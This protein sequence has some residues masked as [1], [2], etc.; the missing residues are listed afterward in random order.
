ME[1]K[2][3]EKAV[4]IWRIYATVLLLV[5]GFLCGAVA[6]F[7]TVIS[8][9]LLA[10]GSAAY[11]GAVFLYLPALYNSYLFRI[12][13]DKIIITKGVIEKKQHHLFIQRVQYVEVN[14]T[15]I[16]KKYKTCTLVFHTAGANLTLHQIDYTVAKQ[17]KTKNKNG[18]TRGFL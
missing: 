15:W 5:T 6:V 13:K 7:S 16:E 9:I 12:L 18:M 8:I 1:Y 17:L 10:A 4:T 2:L 3:S 14:Q 11:A